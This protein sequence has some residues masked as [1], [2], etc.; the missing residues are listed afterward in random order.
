MYTTAASRRPTSR[1]QEQKWR[2]G[3]SE[4]F[5]NNISP[6]CA[7]LFTHAF[8]LIIFCCSHE[9]Y[10]PLH[11]TFPL[12]CAIIFGGTN[13]SIFFYHSKFPSA[14]ACYSFFS[15]FFF[16][17]FLLVFFLHNF[18]FPEQSIEII[19]PDLVDTMVC[20]QHK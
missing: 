2:E 10:F 8:N 11:W 1:K 15:S 14:F 5:A 13:N 20:T 16:I 19:V 7:P 18:H 6:M 9:L 4:S 3:E 12:F 17:F